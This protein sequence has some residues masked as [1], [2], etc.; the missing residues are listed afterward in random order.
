M[1]VYVITSG[2][3]SD[4]G[5]QAVTLNREKAELICAI[6]NRNIR[7]SEDRSK[8]EEYDTDE[9]QCESIGDVGICYTAKFDYKALEIV[10]WGEPFYSFTRNEI[11]RGSI[12]LPGRRVYGSVTAGCLP[13]R[14]VAWHSHAGEVCC[15]VTFNPQRRSGI[16]LSASQS[17]LLT[18]PPRGEPLECRS[19][20]SG[21]RKALWGVS[22]WAP[23]Y[24]AGGESCV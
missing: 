19:G 10:Y 20:L 22:L 8:I 13:L 2:E 6:N 4:Y 5:I 7:Y 15:T 21:M 17:A 18:A 24:R 1:K 12:P 3:Y 9:I 11:K 16:H 14:G 23:L